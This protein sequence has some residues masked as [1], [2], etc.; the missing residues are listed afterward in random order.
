[1]FRQFDTRLDL[2][3]LGK[4]TAQLARLLLGNPASIRCLQTEEECNQGQDKGHGQGSEKVSSPPAQ[5]V[6]RLRLYFCPAAFRLGQSLSRF[7]FP[8]SLGLTLGF[9]LLGH[10]YRRFQ[11]VPLKAIQLAASTLSPL[12]GPV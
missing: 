2:Q 3:L 6:G 8:P 9:F 4:R 1:M 5:L 10:A 11:K 7:Y 12:F